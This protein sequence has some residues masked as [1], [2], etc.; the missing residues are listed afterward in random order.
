MRCSRAAS[1]VAIAIA[2]HGRSPV[3]VPMS[4]F[5]LLLSTL[6]S[7]AALDR[8][9]NAYDA[10]FPRPCLRESGNNH[11]PSS[12][13]ECR[14]IT[15]LSADV[16]AQERERALPRELGGRG[17]VALALIAV[18]AVLGIVE[19]ELRFRMRRGELAR[20]RHRDRRIALAEMRHQPAL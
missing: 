14:R 17:V 1:V 19:E 6:S 7:Q 3:S 10:E 16:L 18:E 5:Y 2:S 12:V 13:G 4:T 20:A 11:P 8:L 9:H 15:V